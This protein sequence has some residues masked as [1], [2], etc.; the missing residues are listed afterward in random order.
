MNRDFQ[1]VAETA[2]NE[3]FI[4]P[5]AVEI[6]RKAFDQIGL[7]GSLLVQTRRYN[8]PDSGRVE[9]RHDAFLIASNE[10]T[11]NSLHAAIDRAWGIL[12][13]SYLPNAAFEYPTGLW[14]VCHSCWVITVRCKEGC[15]WMCYQPDGTKPLP[16]SLWP[17]KKEVP[18][19]FK[20]VAMCI[21]LLKFLIASKSDKTLRREY[22]KLEH[23]LKKEHPQEVRVIKLY[24][25]DILKKQPFGVLKKEC[26]ELCA[27]RYEEGTMTT[28]EFVTEEFAAA[29]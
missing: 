6:L 14:D 1:K 20:G 13:S 25:R 5:V 2:Q 19:F 10:K 21:C 4:D 7:G 23:T 22:S 3:S 18:H 8:E 29:I 26:E 28:S 27:K 24:L 9:M 11:A 16:S 15:V 17:S 12:S